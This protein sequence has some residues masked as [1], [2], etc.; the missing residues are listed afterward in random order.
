MPLTCLVVEPATIVLEDLA[1]TIR[2]IATGATVLDATGEDVA[3]AAIAGLH[4]LDLALVNLPPQGFS[5]TPLGLALAEIGAVV[6]FLGHEVEAQALGRR[7]LERPVLPQALAGV[8]AALDDAPTL[9][10]AALPRLLQ[11]DHPG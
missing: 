8:L 9:D 7:F 3:L 2:E 6:I 5:D 1:M 11:P 10:A 4:A